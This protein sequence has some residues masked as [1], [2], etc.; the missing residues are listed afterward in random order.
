[1]YT[2]KKIHLVESNN[3]RK[4]IFRYLDQFEFANALNELE[5]ATTQFYGDQNDNL[6]LLA[7]IAG[8]Y[9]SLGQESFDKESTEKGIKILLENEREFRT[10]ISHQSF[11]YNLGTGYSALYHIWL[12]KNKPDFLY[13]KN[14]SGYIFDAKQAYLKAF[15]ELDLAALDNTSTSLLT[16]LGLHLKD[17]GRIVE[18]L[19][20][21]D[22]VLKINP[23]FP[24][25]LV[26]KA[27]GLIQMIQ[28]TNCGITV[29]LYA[30]IYSL[31]DDAR[32]KGPYPP[33]LEEDIVAGLKE[34]KKR[35]EMHGFDL[36]RLPKERDLTAKEFSTHPAKLKFMLSNFL[37]LSEHSLYCGCNG[38]AKD[39]LII[40]FEGLNLTNVKIAHLEQLLNQIKSEFSLARTLLY[41]YQTTTE[42]D[43]IHYETFGDKNPIYGVHI[44]KLRTAFRFSF[45][46]LDKIANGLMYLY[47]FKRGNN[48]MIYF[49]V[50]W[51][52]HAERWNEINA[53]QNIHLTALYSI[54]CD[55]TKKD[56]EFNF[57]KK[58]RNQMEHI[59]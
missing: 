38:A 7:E 29:A 16:N 42:T 37:S 36:A 43:N 59:F 19:Q 25:A 35:L 3:L 13:P 17:S 51:R 58:W 46:I 28:T 39:D 2:P 4:K 52:S 11:Y 21:F 18:A 5:S 40:G 45:G 50:F 54:A 23:I 31:F 48:E 12:K 56:G 57:Y 47:D 41:E 9:I 6:L 14:V 34:G 32:N 33:Y 15:K 30:E 1:M 24:N 10:A 53:Q 22:T 20:L 26:S 44:E 27:H 49:D 55:L 8:S